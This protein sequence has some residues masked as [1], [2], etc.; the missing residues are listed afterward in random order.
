MRS[1]YAFHK[2]KAFKRIVKH[3]G[4]LIIGPLHHNDLLDTQAN[5]VGETLVKV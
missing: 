2:R 5:K 3:Q 4:V 1:S